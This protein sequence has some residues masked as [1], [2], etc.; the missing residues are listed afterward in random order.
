[1][2]PDAPEGPAAASMLAIELED[3]QIPLNVNCGLLMVRT[4]SPLGYEAFVDVLGGNAWN[5]APHGRSA[6]HLIK[7]LDPA[8]D[9]DPAASPAD[10]KLFLTRQGRSGKL[11]ETYHLK[12]RLL[13]G[14]ISAAR[15]L[16]RQTQRPLLNL[17]AGSYRVRL[18]DS[19][20]G[21]PFLWTGR[22]ELTDP[23][24]AIELPVENSQDRYYLPGPFVPVVDLPPRGNRRTGPRHRLAAH[25]RHRLGSERRRHHRHLHLPGANQRVSQR[26]GL[27][28][29]ER[30]LRPH[31]RLRADRNGYGAGVGRVADPDGAAQDGRSRRRRISA[32]AAGFRLQNIPFEVV[33]L[34]STPC[35]LY[36]LGV[37]AVRT[38]LVDAGTPLPLALDELLS[39]ARQVANEYEAGVPL[40]TRIAKI[41]AKDNRWLPS[42]GPHRLVWEGLK[43]AE[44]AQLVPIDLWYDTL[45]VI[46]RLFPSIG[47][48]SFCRDYGDA[49]PNGIH[50]AFEAPLAELNAL[51]L[52]SRSLIMVDW[53]YNR[54]VHS[55]IEQCIA[56]LAKEAPPAR[57]PAART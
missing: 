2:T 39:L 38:M 34:L 27:D 35:D 41:F 12:L 29:A 42:T 26:P 52:R 23:G 15:S 51:L 33:P 3:G 44:A 48:D 53:R 19:A 37:L 21:L 46:I 18:G 43:P 17:S 49:R 16:V 6:L 22:V 7:Q 10:G 32:R 55:V 56:T 9:N 14:A 24:D 47:P 4:Y 50:T 45:G 11:I 31:R 1:M 57:K 54:E 20:P 5:G 30:R 28:A 25:P 40:Q 13:A 36:S 8:N